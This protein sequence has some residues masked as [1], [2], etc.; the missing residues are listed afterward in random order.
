M[1]PRRGPKRIGA[2]A[3]S[4][5]PRED[6]FVSAI[7]YPLRR[8]VR[9]RRLRLTVGPGG[10]EV[11]APPRVGEAAIAAFVARHHAWAERKL[12][13]LRAR[14][15]EH[16]GCGRLI[17]GARILYRG[18]PVTLSVRSTA[19]ARSQIVAGDALMVIV[20]ATL[21]EDAR[22]TAVERTLTRWLAGR[23]RADATDYIA[24]HGPAHGLK[25]TAVR[26]K[27]HKRLWGSCTGKGAINL[28]WRLIL[29]PPTVLEYVVVHELC[30][31]RERHHQAAFWR[32]VGEV[33]P[34][35]PAPRRWLRSHGHLLTL[36]PG[37]P[38]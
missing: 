4:G 30:H 23:A 34:G 5:Q 2:A 36:R 22:E 13:A 25:P 17:D 16:P 21:E 18:E 7:P 38:H 3:A 31:L 26:I 12:S 33:L 28:N 27:A 32:L 1:L 8:S 6:R 35:Y 29:A 24:R 15:A 10:V 19:R 9:A 11:V 37:E 14:L 20:P